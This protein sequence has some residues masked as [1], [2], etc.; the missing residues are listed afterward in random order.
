M[1]PP[2]TGR[3]LLVV[4][5]DPEVP[6]GEYGRILAGWGIAARTVHPW[7]QEQL[8]PID[9]CSAVIVLGGAMGVHDTAQ[10]PFLVE[11]KG[12]IQSCMERT[13]PLLG[14]CLGGQ[15]L[16]DALG[17]PVTS[18]S[19]WREKGTLPVTLTDEGGRDPLFA[20]VPSPFV[21]FQ[22]HND[23]FAIPT[24]GVLLASSPACP[25]QAFRVG[26]C[27]WGVQFHPEVDRSIVDTWARWTPATAA[28]LHQFLADFDRQH[29]VYVA[30]SRR[31]LENF[32]RAA[33]LLL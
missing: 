29:P 21:S 14:I 1:N 15:L 25:H 11:V 20:G 28:R 33:G 7:R 22:W 17:A 24:G 8:P 13:V 2:D 19:P 5:N 26:P 16:A 3:P 12:F 27:A 9:S 31:I 10:H 18:G 30:A 32:L 23:S 6:P 4:Q